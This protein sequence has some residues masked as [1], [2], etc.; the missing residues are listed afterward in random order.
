MITVIVILISMAIA[1]Y[2]GDWIKIVLTINKY[3]NSLVILTIDVCWNNVVYE[4]LVGNKGILL[5]KNNKYYG[6]TEKKK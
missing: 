2:F 3:A 6:E 5:S 1:I 4:K